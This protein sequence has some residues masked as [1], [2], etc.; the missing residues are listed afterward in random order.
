VSTVASQINGEFEAK[1]EHMK[2]Y[3]NEVKEPQ[4]RFKHLTI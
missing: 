2:K 4:N 1:E 3:L